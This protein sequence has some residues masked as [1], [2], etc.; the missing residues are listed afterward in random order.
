M[1]QKVTTVAAC[2]NDGAKAWA[3]HISN[4]FSLPSWSSI[5]QHGF[6]ADNGLILGFKDLPSSIT[7]TDSQF[8]NYPGFVIVSNSVVSFENATFSSGNTNGPGEV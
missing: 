3:C 2:V 6:V 1:H 8:V 7:V 5:E 4:G